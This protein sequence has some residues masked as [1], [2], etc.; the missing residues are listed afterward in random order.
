MYYNKHSIRLKGYDYSSSGIYYITICIKNREEI[1]SKII[2]VGADDPV[3][4]TDLNIMQIF[5]LNKIKYILKLTEIGRIVSETWN[6]I[7][8]IFKNT[9]LHEYIIMPNHIHGIIE[10]KNLDEMEWQMGGQ[11]RPPLHKIIQGFK[12]VTTRE[13]FKFGYRNIWQKN[14]Y[15]HIIRNKQE[16]YHI[17]EYIKDNPAKFIEN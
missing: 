6:K 5:N 8:I 10:I 16:Y 7:P 15:E 17:C 14:Y 13:C 4:P 2:D 12:S 9:K 1:L 11:G 3:R